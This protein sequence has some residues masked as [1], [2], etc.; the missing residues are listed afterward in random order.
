VSGPVIKVDFPGQDLTAIYN[1]LW[2][3]HRIAIAKTDA[4]DAAGLRFSPHI[5]N[6]EAEVDKTLGALR[7]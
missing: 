2:A 3:K 5:Y 4:G 1:R 7:L 6:T